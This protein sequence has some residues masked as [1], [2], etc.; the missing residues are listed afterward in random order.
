MLY[1]INC[2]ISKPPE[3]QVYPETQLQKSY[4]RVVELQYHPVHG[5]CKQIS[6]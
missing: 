6:Y 5:G 1:Y 3:N 4:C 2:Q